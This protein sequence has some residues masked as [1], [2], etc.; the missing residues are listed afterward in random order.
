M[1]ILYTTHCPKCEVLKKKLNLKGIEFYENDS[2]E[3]MLDLKILNVPVLSINEGG[4]LL[5]FEEA[6]K[7]VNE[8]EGQ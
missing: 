4:N 2:V 3:E 6:V 5:S 1:T 8:Q 7:W